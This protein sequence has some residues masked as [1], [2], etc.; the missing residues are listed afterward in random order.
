M[1]QIT[2][3]NG[4]YRDEYF[5][6]SESEQV[7][8]AG[9]WLSGASGGNPATWPSIEMLVI[10]DAAGDDASN[11]NDQYIQICN[12]GRG[13]LDLL[14]WTV[15]SS[16]RLDGATVSIPFNTI[17]SVRGARIA[18]MLA[19]VWRLRQKSILGF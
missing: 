11:L 7:A 5:A 17:I 15:R 2:K 9:M 14:N 10:Y 6:A 18:S 12:T 1:R 3:W 16:A 19:Q 13:D 8:Q 4:G